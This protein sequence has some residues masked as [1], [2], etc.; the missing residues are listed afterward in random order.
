MVP[1]SRGYLVTFAAIMF[2]PPRN[3][4]PHRDVW[5]RDR[6]IGRGTGTRAGIDA[7]AKMQFSMTLNK[8]DEIDRGA[9]MPD[10]PSDGSRGTHSR[11]FLRFLVV[12][13][14]KI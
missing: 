12:E 10:G 7:G 1:E 8:F 4:G 5:T 11:E 13:F 2:N 14:R 6:V 3:N 9:R